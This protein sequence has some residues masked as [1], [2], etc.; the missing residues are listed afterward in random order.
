VNA[1]EPLQDLT[2]YIKILFPVLTKKTAK[3]F[4]L[5]S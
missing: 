1:Q 5:T 2:F 4:C 3:I